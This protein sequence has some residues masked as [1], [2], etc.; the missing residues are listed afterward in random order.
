MTK[1][2]SALTRIGLAI[3]EQ[4]ADAG[5]S[6]SELARLAGVS[7]STLT[8]IERGRPIEPRLLL[9][10]AAVLTLLEVYAPIP[11]APAEVLHGLP[12][13]LWPIGGAA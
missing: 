10:I 2:N 4:R 1:R 11:R 6:L 5:L 9:Q 7:R 3:P 8:K 13:V 12:T